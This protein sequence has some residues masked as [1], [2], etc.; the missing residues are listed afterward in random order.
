MIDILRDSDGKI[1]FN[2]SD[3]VLGF[4]DFQ[5]QHHL[6]I[7]EKGEL[8]ENETS[9]VGLQNFINDA[10]IDGMLGEV[11]SQFT[12]DGMEVKKVKYDEETF[13]LEFDANY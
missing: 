13:N 10:D 4:S 2:N 12:K 8:K 3:V 9:G 7:F 6:L 1:V 5:H 11:K